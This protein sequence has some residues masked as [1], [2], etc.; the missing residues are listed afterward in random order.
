MRPVAA[1]PQLLAALLSLAACGQ[2]STTS[3]PMLSPPLMRARGTIDRAAKAHPHLSYRG[4]RVLAHAQLSHIYW[5]SYWSS[6]QGR[7]DASFYDLFSQTMSASAR[8]FSVTREYSSAEHPIAPGWFRKSL[9]VASEPG[10]DLSDAQIQAFL[11]QQLDAGALPP[12][13]DDQVYVVY[14]PPGTVVDDGTG[15]K[16]CGKFCGYHYSFLR[17]RPVHYIVMPHPDCWGCRF[18]LL[19]DGVD[20]DDLNRDST[21]IILSHELIETATDPDV[22]AGQLGW[23]DDANGEIG[24]I[25]GGSDGYF[26][27]GQLQGFRVQKQWSNA[28]DKC[29]LERDIPL[30][31]GGGCPAATH[32]QGRLCVPDIPA[33]CSSAGE[34]PALAVLVALTMA[35]TRRRRRAGDTD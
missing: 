6:G 16:S 2:G 33:S 20:M 4:G 28:D 5:G 22:G 8:L 25:C 17:E 11:R 13:D 14:L 30:Q 3:S 12:P 24:D 18:A 19:H 26:D 34:A 7:D 1:P 23:Y 15:Q 10:S 9:K 32:A 31:P 27:Q 35:W 21:T 29:Q